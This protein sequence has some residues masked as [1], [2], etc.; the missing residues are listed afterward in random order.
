MYPS[1]NRPLELLTTATL[2]RPSRIRRFSQSVLSAEG[3]FCTADELIATMEVLEPHVER[4]WDDA[5]SIAFG[6]DL[7]T[8]MPSKHQKSDAPPAHEKTDVASKH[9]LRSQHM[10]LAG[11]AIE[12]LCKGYLARQLSQ[13]R[14]AHKKSSVQP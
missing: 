9:D 6:V 7:T 14:S 11:F 13:N 4:F 8:G 2:F 12:N 3:W 10:M 1:E 5:R